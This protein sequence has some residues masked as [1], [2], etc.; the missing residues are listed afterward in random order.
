MPESG[1]SKM[2]SVRVNEIAQKKSASTPTA[3][4]N[5]ARENV[6]VA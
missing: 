3:A 4:A 2:V 1:V 6:A 5:A